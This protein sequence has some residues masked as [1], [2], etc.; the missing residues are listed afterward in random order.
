MVLIRRLSR[1]ITRVINIYVNTDDHSHKFNICSSGGQHLKTTW[2]NHHSYTFYI[3]VAEV[4]IE[5]YQLHVFFPSCN[6]IMVYARVN[7]YIIRITTPP[8]PYSPHMDSQQTRKR[9]RVT[10]PWRCHSD[11]NIYVKE[12][13]PI[14][15]Q[16]NRAA[17]RKQGSISSQTNVARKSNYQELSL[18]MARRLSSSWSP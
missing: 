9:T 8:S 12:C 7:V 6:K 16:K 1:N 4:F 13:G 15:D 11:R 17:Q 5:R 3:L 14:T 2:M 18:T 10:I